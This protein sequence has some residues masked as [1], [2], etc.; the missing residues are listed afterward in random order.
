MSLRSI[1]ATSAAAGPSAI[2][3]ERPVSGIAGLRKRKGAPEAPL[4]STSCESGLLD[5]R[6]QPAAAMGAHEG[7]DL[8]R[9]GRLRQAAFQDATR[10][11]VHQGVD[12]REAQSHG[13]ILDIAL[14][15]GFGE[16]ALE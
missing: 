10:G 8:G 16:I 3:I 11:P 12:Q 15:P 5:R 13:R 14:A 4:R 1:S 2:S 9:L 7:P 6:Q